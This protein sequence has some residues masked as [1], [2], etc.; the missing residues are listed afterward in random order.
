MLRR[1]RFPDGTE[2]P[3]RENAKVIITDPGEGGFDTTRFLSSGIGLKMLK[4][5]R[6]E[7][8][9]SPERG[10]L[11]SFP[12]SFAVTTPMLGKTVKNGKCGKQISV[13][14]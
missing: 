8:Q 10:R 3:R 1:V 5:R 4:Y 12:K 6:E 2:G 14:R 11:Q 9:Y 13:N 7:K